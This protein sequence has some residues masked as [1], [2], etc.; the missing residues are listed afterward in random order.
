MEDNDLFQDEALIKNSN[1]IQNNIP[2]L[3]AS[4]SLCKILMNNKI[5]SGF[6]IKFFRGSESFFCLTTNEH[7]ITKTMVNQ[8]EKISF[9]FDNEAETREI[10]LD[11]NERYI[12]DFR[13]I[14]LDV[15][16]IEILPKEN[17]SKEYFL[18]TNL[19]YLNEPNELINQDI[20]ILHYPSGVSSHSFGKIIDVK[21]NKLFHSASTL[22]G[23]S[24]APIF[25]K[26]NQKV[27]GIH[28]GYSKKEE[29]NN[30][31]FIGPIFNFFKNI[32]EKSK[33]NN[34]IPLNISLIN[35]NNNN[36]NNNNINNNN[37][38]I[39]NNKLNQMTIILTFEKAPK[40][41]Q[42]FSREFVYNNKNNCYLLIEDQKYELSSNIILNTNKDRG[43]YLEIKLIE[44]HPIIN[45]DSLFYSE[46][47]LSDTVSE[48]TNL[49]LYRDEYFH[50]NMF[51]NY[52]SSISLPDIAEWDTKNVESMGG[53]FYNCI[54]LI[55][56][57]DIS[58]WDT[59]NVESMSGMFYNC[60]SLISLPDISKWNTQNVNNFMQMFNN[61]TSLISLP[62]ISKWNTKHAE[63][64]SQMFKNCTSLIS[65]PDISKW[66]TKKV[67]F[68]DQMFCNCT[69]LIS[70][71]DIS[72]W[73]TKNVNFLFGMFSNCT[74]LKSLSDI[75]KWEIKHAYGLSNMFNNCISLKSLPHISKWNTKRID[76]M[77]KMF[78]NC[79]S[80]I[81]LPH[82]SKWDT[83]NVKSMK[84]MFC[85]CKSLISLPD[86]S[87]WDTRNVTNMEKM[88][89]NCTSLISLPNISKW[90]LNQDLNKKSMFTNCDENII[91]EIFKSNCL[92]Y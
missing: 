48:I 14:D 55:S 39:N 27:I 89:Y 44:T 77:E 66:N 26:N 85:N 21:N 32:Q 23:S 7:S 68:M 74:S 82:I 54:S 15:I 91:P 58:K 64:L 59:K 42:L 34:N 31:I 41:I 45:M 92:I 25:L 11:P 40:N 88:F 63:S 57:P 38:N 37:N 90:K 78:C 73:D 60:T 79:T 30:G 53:M 62:D 22:P 65:L 51:I 28:K 2:L 9:Y 87:K 24:G 20:V 49:V 12:K 50:K 10:I 56:L 67:E 47:S 36:N 81:S 6:L 75:S 17:I 43:N 72:K 80:L 16:V 46:V 83:K 33:I 18:L 4:K 71:P 8:R 69:S 19:N 35:N 76:D 29:K 13:D 3:Q 86:I 70:I 1:I 61:C 52:P 5:S 84:G